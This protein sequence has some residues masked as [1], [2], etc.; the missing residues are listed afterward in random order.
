MQLELFLALA[1]LLTGTRPSAQ[2][3]M[4][5]GIQVLLQQLNAARRMVAA[6]GFFVLASSALGMSG[7]TQVAL[8][9]S[10]KFSELADG[11]EKASLTA[12]MTVSDWYSLCFAYSKIKHYSKLPKCL[13][14]LEGALKS[15]DTRTRI[16]GMEDATGAVALLRAEYLVEMADFGKGLQT[17]DAGIS[18]FNSVKSDDLNI[19][20]DLLA[21]QAI[22]RTHL[23][24]KQAARAIAVRLEQL[25]LGILYSDFVGAKSLALARVHMALG[26]WQKVLD[27]L[28][29]DRTLALRSFLDNL[30]S[31][32]YLRGHNNWVWLEL[33]R[34]YMRLKAL[35]ELGNLE[36]SRQGFDELLRQ[37]AI[38]ANTEIYW[39]LL[40]D[41]AQIAE[42]EGLIDA[43]IGFYAEAA[44][45]IESRRRTIHSEANKIGFIGDKQ[46]VYRKL[47]ALQ[48]T[49]KR[50]D[51]VVETMS[52]AKSRALVDLLASKNASTLSAQ[53][54]PDQQRI[55]QTLEL[56]DATDISARGQGDSVS[57][58]RPATIA[59]DATS[60]FPPKLGDLL[61]TRPTR[62]EDLRKYLT[63]EESVLIYFG[64]RNLIYA[65]AVTLDS[66]HVV[67]LDVLDL[68]AKVAAARKAI[69]EVNPQANELMQKLYW[70]IFAPVRPHLRGT[71][72]T[73]VA[74]GSLHYLPFSALGDGRKYLI[75]DYALRQIPSLEIL[76]Y[77]SRSKI[78]RV[79]RLLIFGNPDL[80]NPRHDLPFA[81]TEAEQLWAVFK[82]E[83]NTRKSASR[84]AFLQKAPGARFIHIASH[85]EFDNTKPLQSGLMFSD[86]RVGG[87]VASGRVTAG[88]LYETAIDADVVTLSACET[89]LGSV[90]N[91]DDVIG[92]TRGFLYAGARSVFASLWLVDDE[93]TST[94]M[95][96]LYNNFL[97]SDRAEALRQAQLQTRSD[98]PHPFYWAS[99]FLTGE[100]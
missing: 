90:E 60:S 46:H 72:L 2:R 13:D 18:W 71:K 20:I 62:V 78:E 11:L 25:P 40:S 77:G 6:L 1:T 86:E 80:G 16:F 73:I 3:L 8:A 89:G 27:A 54:G 33:P 17:A 31:G 66:I 55:R 24:E 99:F 93:A 91:G 88:D 30:A 65:A 15:G 61:Q 85:G 12:K 21:V 7:N 95:L 10:G 58:E 49:A 48:F 22:A 38:R 42:S 98:Y 69:Q 64:D 35:L 37:P 34:A 53:K 39:M 23:G 41:R 19:L 26:N 9:G 28:Q 79:D 50:F 82:G 47:V 97:V 70:E 68:G 94:L 45:V 29:T 96:R 76:K 67:R 63:A 52:R 56:F 92:L 32:A 57:S 43:A 83:L 84:Q 4:R 36:V 59:A 81:Q 87:T 100:D 75:D 74:H 51:S 14:S 44:T 5:A